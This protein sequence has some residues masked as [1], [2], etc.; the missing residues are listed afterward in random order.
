LEI[1]LNKKGSQ[2]KEKSLELS[3]REMINSF[4]PIIVLGSVWQG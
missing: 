1:S 4:G 2:K 3:W